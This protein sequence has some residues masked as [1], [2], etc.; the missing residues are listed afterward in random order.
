MEARE[1]FLEEVRV[2]R[3]ENPLLNGMQTIPQVSIFLGQPWLSLD[4]L[5]LRAT[6]L[7]FL[8]LI[9]PLTCTQ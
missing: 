5:R 2:D 8:F 4:S 7:R 6:Y 3:V 9:L 1:G